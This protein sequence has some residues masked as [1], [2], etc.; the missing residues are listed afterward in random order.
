M[1]ITIEQYLAYGKAHGMTLGQAVVA[2]ITATQPATFDVE[3]NGSVV[4]CN[5]PLDAAREHAEMWRSFGEVA[6]RPCQ[7]RLST[8]G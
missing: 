2:L 1:K 8:A 4:G 7:R 5:M 3:L 6:I